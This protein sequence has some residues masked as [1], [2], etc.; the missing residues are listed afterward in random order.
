M[1][2][3]SGRTYEHRDKL[4]SLRGQFDQSTKQWSFWYLSQS[5]IAELKSLVGV[6]VNEKGARVK[7]EADF[8]E[9]EQSSIISG[10]PPFPSSTGDSAVDRL[11][12]AMLSEDE[13]QP[14]LIGRND[15]TPIYGDDQRYFNYFKDQ[16]PLAFFGF[17]SLSKMV[18]YVEAIPRDKRTGDR[19]AGYEPGEWAGTPDMPAALKLARHGW[20]Q[21]VE[22]AQEIIE[23]LGVQ[24]ATQRRRKHAVA[25]G[26]VSVGRMLAGNPAHMTNRPKQPGR[27]IVTLFAECGMSAS[28][29]VE[30]MIARAAIIAAIADILEREGYSCEIVSLVINSRFGSRP[31]SHT[32]VTVKQAGERL[33]LHDAVFALGHPSFLR[34]LSFAC[35]CSS[36]ECEPIWETQGSPA[37][38]FNDKHPTGRNEFFI[39]P[40]TIE[41]QSQIL[42]GSLRNRALSMMEFV[43]PHNLPIEINI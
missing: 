5:E 42:G 1:I 13:K 23:L 29:K 43:K 41:Q 25:G 24:H 14:A 35:V 2:I 20:A 10:V 37:F 21:G 28:I 6:I 4:K 16:N 3:A 8:G 27:K 33:N 36:D 22:N 9:D 30:N 18:D 39:R 12:A 11:L 31:G 17:S 32:A 7:I 40:L 19:D 38:A 34:R 15:N 26:S